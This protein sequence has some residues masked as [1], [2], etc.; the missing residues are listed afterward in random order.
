MKILY[1]VKVVSDSP[2]LVG[3]LFGLLN[4]VDNLP[5]RQVKFLGNFKLQNCN[6]SCWSIIF[7]GL[8]EMMFGLVHASYNL[9]EWQAVNLTFFAPCNL[10]K[11]KCMNQ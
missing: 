11:E 5:D 10:W 1:G 8:V 7:G 9:P 6:Q 4:S 2:G 3:F